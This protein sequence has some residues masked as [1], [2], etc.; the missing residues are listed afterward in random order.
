VRGRV[1]I[2]VG[3]SADPV[4]ILSRVPGLA[5]LPLEFLSRSEEAGAV[6]VVAAQAAERECGRW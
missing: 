1:G 6:G 5:A 2:G 4:T 3:D